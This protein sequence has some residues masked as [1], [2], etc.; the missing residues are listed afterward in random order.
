MCN[1]M[2]CV[3]RVCLCVCFLCIRT[4]IQVCDSG[5]G[6]VVSYRVCTCVDF[7]KANFYTE[8]IE[9]RFAR[10]QRTGTNGFPVFLLLF[11]FPF[12]FYNSL[13]FPNGA[14]LLSPPSPTGPPNSELADLGLLLTIVSH[15]VSLYTIIRIC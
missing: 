5:G 3:S 12:P 14:L 1:C 8:F 9:W 2:V 6:I 15:P 11:A 13:R 4:C 7:C 10:S